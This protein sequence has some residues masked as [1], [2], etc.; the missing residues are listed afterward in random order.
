MKPIPLGLRTGLALLFTGGILLAQSQAI[1]G[2]LAGDAQKEQDFET[3]ARA[4]PDPSLMAKYMEFMAA[5]PHQAGSPRSKAVAEY[6]EGVFRN[7]GLDPQVEQFS[8]LLP[9]PTVR[10]LQVIGPKPYEARLKE[11][12]VPQDPDSAD[13]NQLPTYNAY[14]ASG[15]V[16][17]EVV[18]ANFGTPDDYDWLAKKGVDVKGKIVLTRYG[19]TWRGIKPKLAAEH[20]AIACIIYSDPREDGFFPGDIFPAGPMRPW[21]GVQRGSVMDMPYYPGDPL[22]PGWASVEGARRLPRGEAKKSTAPVP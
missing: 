15:D 14:S 20:G 21:Q 12:V 1:R 8:V 22:T 7:W 11:P 5:E 18:Y 6:I 19:E 13:R 3:K 9:Y 16:T 4:I 2:F 17:G 10:S